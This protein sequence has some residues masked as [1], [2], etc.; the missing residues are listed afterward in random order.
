M[1][2]GIGPVRFHQLL[3]QCGGP[4]AAWEASDFDLVRA[5]LERRTIE[6]L[7]SL[8]RAT[9]PEHIA[10]Q[11]TARQIHALTLLD[12][13][14]P[15]SLRTIGDPP[16]VLFVRGDLLESDAWSVAIVGTRRA[17]PYGY[18]VAQ[19]LTADLAVAGVTVVSGLAKGVDTAAHRAALD[20][21][22]R[23]LAVLG[24]GLDQVYPPE[25]TQL[26]R[27]IP[28]AGAL[29]SEFPPGTPPDAM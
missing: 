8:R 19:R 25:N 16:P 3:N 2:S 7:N 27:R 13:D 12:D 29:I 22:G 10:G 11:L 28:D 17:S 14:Y 1:A 24:H 23:T 4:R 9:S 18:A 5:K 26:A 15:D 20:V 21:G 6:S